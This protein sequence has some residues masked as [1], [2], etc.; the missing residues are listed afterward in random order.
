[1]EQTSLSH[2]TISHRTNDLSDNIKQTLKERLRL[3]V[4]FSLDLDE[5]TDISDTALLVI[6]IRAVTVGFDVVEEFL[7][8]ASLS[9]TTTGQNNCQCVIRV[10]E[11]FKLNP[12]ILCGLI[13]DGGP[14]ITG[15]TNGKFI[16]LLVDKM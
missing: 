1:M 6:F 3:C 16:M 9:S 4:A 15:R 8:M 14:S 11:R 7:N 5:S 13:A 12:A 2:F 10:V